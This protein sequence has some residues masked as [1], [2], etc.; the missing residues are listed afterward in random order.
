MANTFKWTIVQ[1]DCST[2]IPE[3]QDYVVTAHW[4]Y[5]ITDGTIS[6]DMYGAT[7]FPVD[8]EKPNFVP[9]AELQESDVIGWLESELD[10]DA[11]QTSLTT[12]LD[13]IINPPIVS[14]PLPWNVNPAE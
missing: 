14:P 8:P 7:S 9:F 13:N 5:G 1:L 3:V 11:M 4:R 6:T 12:Q 2:T 10:V